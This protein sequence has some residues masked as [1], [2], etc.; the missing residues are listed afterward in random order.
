MKCP[1]CGAE[2]KQGFQIT[3]YKLWGSYK[4]AKA[5]GVVEVGKQP[6]PDGAL[7]KSTGKWGKEGTPKMVPLFEQHPEEAD[8]WEAELQLN[9]YRVMLGDLGIK[10]HKLQVQVTV[11]DGGLFI[12]KDRGISR[13]IYKIPV[14]IL[15]DDEVRGYFQ[16][17]DDCLKQA[18]EHGWTE[19]CSMRECWD[20]VRCRDYC[21]VS[22]LC[23]KGQIIKSLGGKLP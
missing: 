14:K 21:E 18:L 22:E 5:L 19:P 3:D 15:P 2:M 10:V 8:N 20:G 7:Y 4:V 6:S 13:K 17:K 9:R 11:R 12:A 23:S 1:K 16:V